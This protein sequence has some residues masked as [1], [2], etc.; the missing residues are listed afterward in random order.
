MLPA[1]LKNVFPTC[2]VA[3]FLYPLTLSVHGTYPS[4]TLSH[5]S[6]GRPV[7][8]SLLS[9]R[10]RGH[11]RQK[12]GRRAGATHLPNQRPPSFA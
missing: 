5:P 3:P 12:A 2:L 11:L 4:R 10:P 8:D 7:H 9:Q 6:S 1:V